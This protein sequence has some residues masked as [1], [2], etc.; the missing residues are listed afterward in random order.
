MKNKN[1]RYW[2]AKYQVESVGVNYGE[3]MEK[4]S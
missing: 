4:S 1:C 2:N 3:E